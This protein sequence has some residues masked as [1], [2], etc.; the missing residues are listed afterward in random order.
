MAEGIIECAVL[1]LRDV[2]VF[3][4]MVSPLYVGR[5]SSFKAIESALKKNS[6]MIAIPQLNP[7][8]EN[9]KTC[10][11]LNFGIE[12]AVLKPVVVNSDTSATLIQG[13]RRLEIL[14]FIQTRPHMIARAK[15]VEETISNDVEAQA[16]MRVTT[17]LF[18]N[19]VELSPQLPDEAATH[20][21]T[22]EQPGLL[23][24]MISMAF[25]LPIE[26]QHEL[27][28]TANPL[29]RLERLFRLV[30]HEIDVLTLEKEIHNKV[31]TEFDRN[32]RE[33]YLREQMRT[34]QGELGEGDPWSRELSDLHSKIMKAH[35]PKEVRNRALKELNRLGYMPPMSPEVGVIRTYL[36]W[37]MEIPWFESTEDNLDITN[38]SKVLDG[39]HYGLPKVKDRILEYIAVRKLLNKKDHGPHQPILCF[40]GPPGT[41]KTSLGRSIAESLGKEF[42]RLSLGGVHDEAEIRGHR[43]TYIGAMPGRI[44]QTL[45]RAGVTNPLFMLDEID[46]LSSDYRGDPSSALLEVLDPEQNHAFSDNY[47][48]MDYDLSQVMFITTANRDDT[49]PWALLDRMELIE[50]PGYVEEE[51]LE[52]SRQFLIPRQLDENG[53]QKD[54]V[55]FTDS[56]LQCI[57]RDYT[58]EAGVRNLEREIGRV[59]RKVARLKAEGKP[60]PKEINDELVQQLIGPAEYSPPLVGREEEV[61]V[62]N[63]LAWT[64]SGGDITIVEVLQTEGKGNLQLT[65]QLGTVMQES[66][67]AAL[68]YLKSKAEELDIDTDVFEETDVHVHLPEGAIRKD[69]PSAGITIAAGIISVFT[70]RPVR[71]DIG[72]TGEITLRGR[73]L[74]VG[75]VREKVLAAYRAGLT[76]VILPELN[77]K[78]LMDIPKKVVDELNFIFVKHMDEVVGAALLDPLPQPE[79]EEESDEDKQDTSASAPEPIPSSKGE[80][81]AVTSTA[82]I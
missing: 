56:A 22:I 28:K 3:P 23:A 36:D 32:Q 27:L 24:D 8:T 1:P 65:G 50:F 33:N 20:A 19:L 10:D 25:T 78:D 47:L 49:I 82:Q 61:G 60:Q 69:G 37:L 42:V 15:I 46:K 72:M 51:K 81:P 66:A 71:C 38:A 6:T 26:I 55:S 57:I 31:K 77:E 7:A 64:M 34:I 79:T 5:D 54:E 62:V 41:G 35:L 11:F 74:P 2:I 29:V 43:R 4:R 80:L 68:S 59:C 67:Q 76:T 70:N 16:L 58:Y 48:E 9:P 30:T 13:R 73:V 39:N 18:Q 14:E 17:K 40:V 75:G 52:I 63:G 53:L 12:V 44:L 45:K 21:F